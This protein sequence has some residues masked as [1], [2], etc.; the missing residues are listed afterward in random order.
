[1]FGK[2]KSVLAITVGIAIFAVFSLALWAYSSSDSAQAQQ[3]DDAD[4]TPTP[5]AQPTPFGTLIVR[6]F[7][8]EE[9]A[10]YLAPQTA[11]AQSSEATPSNAPYGDLDVTVPQGVAMLV[12][13]IDEP[14]GATKYR[15]ERRIVGPSD[16]ETAWEYLVEKE[17]PV[18][19]ILEYADTDGM[20]GFE[21]EYQVTKLTNTGAEP[22]VSAGRH[23]MYSVHYLYGYGVTNAAQLHIKRR[24]WDVQ[25]KYRVWRYSSRT[26]ST[27]VLVGDPSVNT[28]VTDPQPT[29]FYRYKVEYVRSDGEGGWNVVESTNEIVV[30]IEGSVLANP[31]G[32]VVSHP[33][34][35]GESRLTWNAPTGIH[36]ANFGMYEIL[37]RNAKNIHD[38]YTIIA[39]TPSPSYT[40]RYA[41]EGMH[42]GYVVRAVDWNHDRSALSAGITAPR[43]PAPQCTVTD[44]EKLDVSSIDLTGPWA[45]PEND[46]YVFSAWLVADDGEGIRFACSEIDTS[47]WYVVRRTVY[48]HTISDD[49]PTEQSCD[50]VGGTSGTAERKFK[51]AVGSF[52]TESNTNTGTKA[53]VWY[54]DPESQSGLYRYA[55]RMCSY[56]RGLECKEWLGHWDFEGVESIPF[57]E[58]I[59]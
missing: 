20:P 8:D 5:E 43:I 33:P 14:D 55:Y 21:Y 24:A 11:K 16:F 28:S 51:P 34:G 58:E 32:L 47:D 48:K 25:V 26:D 27:P 9:R 35:L 2:K 39:S 42:F 15:F 41:V 44:D 7:T 18:E 52:L 56:A 36:R 3:H 40:D 38:R 53:F 46:R 4:P 6:D 10:N 37:R 31:R 50:L 22:A 57:A 29:G 13:N 17:P 12:L 30:K 23:P 19:P 59:P 54:D 45:P 1:M 49:C